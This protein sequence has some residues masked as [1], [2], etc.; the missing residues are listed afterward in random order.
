EGIGAAY[1]ATLKRGEAAE[2]R[3]EYLPFNGLQ[4]AAE[5]VVNA[6][7]GAARGVAEGAGFRF[8]GERPR[9]W[10]Q[11]LEALGTEDALKDAMGEQGG[12][13]TQ[14]IVGTVADIGLDPATYISLGGSA[15]FRGA[16]RGVKEATEE[17]ARLGS[18]GA[19]AF[20][21]RVAGGVKGA[22]EDMAARR[23]EMFTERVDRSLNKADRRAQNAAD[24]ARVANEGLA[25]EQAAARADIDAALAG[26][27]AT[28]ESAPVPE[29][30]VEPPAQAVPAPIIDP[31]V[32]RTEQLL[33][34]LSA[35]GARVSVPAGRILA[36]A[37]EPAGG[38]GLVSESVRAAIDEVVAAGD[39]ARLRGD[40]AR[41]SADPEVK[42]LLDT[43]VRTASGPRKVRDLVRAAVR[44]TA[45]RGTDL[46]ARTPALA[47]L[48][49]VFEA[50]EAVP[51]TAPRLGAAIDAAF[52]ERAAAG[53]APVDVAALA[54]ELAAATPGQQRRILSRTLGFRRAIRF[55]SFDEALDAAVE[56]RVD[57]PQM[58]QMLRALGI[59][60]EAKA[61]DTLQSILSTRG[62]ANWEKAKASIP[63]HDEVLEAHSISRPVDEAADQIDFSAVRAGYAAEADTA[64]RS[65]FGFD[66]A[67]IAPNS[68]SATGKA[69][70]EAT[71]ELGRMF[72]K[73]NPVDSYADDAMIAVHKTV[74]RQLGLAARDL[75]GWERA[76]A[77][78]PRYLQATDLIES[79]QRGL[80]I[81]PRF[82]DRRATDPLFVSWG[83]LLRELPEDVV[84][85]VLFSPVA[86]RAT[87][88]AE[89]AIGFVNGMTLYVNHIANGVKAALGG[90]PA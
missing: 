56:G 59:R 10:G 14:G 88:D 62:R 65:A 67:K 80:G 87:R 3:G 39:P 8:D 63:T 70:F 23:A 53:Q 83:Q 17:A 18:T 29:R 45:Q 85:L 74:M 84:K 16:A 24:R 55:G 68:G 33:P 79:Y 11:N 40:I 34:K 73:G 30:F 89:G 66:A 4:G 22:A 21:R 32:A 86:G 75:S 46:A 38:G 50:A 36:A 43:E 78:Y 41:I 12:G 1:D 71:Q 48:E 2:K 76:N 81:L 47:D 27:R 61:P 37:T 19:G 90:A 25:A 6:V 69:V 60:S 20:A 13:F 15:A 35:E 9:T 49:R 51:L 52:P 28:P 77:L 42:A 57:A 54:D 44:E 82:A 72:A 31:A 26:V 5:S 58:R 7:G 64:I